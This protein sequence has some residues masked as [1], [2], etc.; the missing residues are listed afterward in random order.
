MSVRVAYC[1]VVGLIAYGVIRNRFEVRC[2]AAR[3]L[4]IER[5]FRVAVSDAR[6]LCT[7]APVQ[8]WCA[9]PST[10]SPEPCTLHPAPCTL[11][12]GP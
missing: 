8:M 9:E 6:W 7:M 12:P 3:T 4:R 10:L 11:N 2:V 5:M 1:R